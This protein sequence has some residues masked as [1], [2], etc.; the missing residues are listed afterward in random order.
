MGSVVA[1][2]GLQST[3]S[4]T[5]MQGLGYSTSCGI[6]PDEGSNL[7]LL[8]WQEDS[9]PLIYKGSLEESLYNLNTSSF[10]GIFSMP[11]ILLI[12][13]SKEQKFLI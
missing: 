4:V 7:C 2:P 6:F 10:S 3:G 12:M 8:H 9:L 11:L 1:A 5:A 13:F